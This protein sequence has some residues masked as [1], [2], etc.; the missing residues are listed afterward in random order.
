MLERVE[1]RVVVNPDPRLK[2]TARDRGWPVHN[3]LLN[4]AA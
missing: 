4:K 3:W 1:N 2:R